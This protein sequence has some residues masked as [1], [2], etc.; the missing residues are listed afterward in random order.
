MCVCV[1]LQV[2]CEFVRIYICGCVCLST[3][4]RS[5]PMGQQS[6]SYHHVPDRLLH[7]GLPPGVLTISLQGWTIKKK[8]PKNPATSLWSS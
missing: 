7:T 5:K 8:T 4:G 1:S 6:F 3:S 2:D